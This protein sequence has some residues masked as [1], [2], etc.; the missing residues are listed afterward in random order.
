MSSETILPRGSQ[1][2]SPHFSRPAARRVEPSRPAGR[3]SAPLLRTS[4]LTTRQ[5]ERESPLA[6]QY[7][8]QGLRLVYGFN[9]AEAIRSFTRATEL[10]PACA[11]CWWGIAYAYG[12][13]VNAGMD[14]ASGVQ[15]YEAAQ[16]ALSPE[17]QRKPVGARLYPRGGRALR[18]GAARQSRRARLRV[19]PR[20]GRRRP[21]LSERSR[22]RGAVR[23]V[24]DGSA[25]LELLDAGGKAV[26][27]HR[28]DRATAGA[29]HRAESGASRRLPLLHP[30]R[31][32][33][34]SAARGAL[35]RA[36][37]APDAGCGTHGAHAGAH[38][39]PR[40]PV[41][42]RRRRATCTRSTPTRRSSRARSR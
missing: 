14:S 16:K 38:L 25:A 3:R 40:R 5:S 9:H 13:H 8:D 24:A 39:R 26:S 28:G 42:R 20:D 6:Q 30:R 33:G 17:P 36:S 31:R 18:A 34:E 10:D 11:M 22:R 7:F 27:R 32:G 23:R 29:S 41:Q 2:D 21:E 1:D 12:P 35:R 37:G 19:R 15:A 4:A